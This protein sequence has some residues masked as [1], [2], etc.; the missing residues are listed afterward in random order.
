MH[1]YDVRIWSVRK[2]PS[3][4]APYQLRWQVDGTEFPEKFAT[5]TLAAP[6]C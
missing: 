6:N 5:K 3:K 4:P 2:R 1:S